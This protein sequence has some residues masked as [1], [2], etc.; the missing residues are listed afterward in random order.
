MANFSLQILHMY[1]ESGILAVDT[2]PKLAALVDKFDD[3]PNTVVIAEGDTWIPGPFLVGGA[4]P[5]LNPVPGIGTTALGR[6]D[7]AILNALGTTVSALGNHEFDLGS[8]VVSAAIAES[9]SGNS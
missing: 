9:G 5:S 3:T 2:A 7:I 6:P 4:D 1:G 8:P